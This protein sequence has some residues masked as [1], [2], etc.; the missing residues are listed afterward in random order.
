MCCETVTFVSECSFPRVRPM[1]ETSALVTMK[2]TSALATMA[3]VTQAAPFVAESCP[4]AE[5]ESSPK[6]QALHSLLRAPTR[7]GRSLATCANLAVPASASTTLSELLSRALRAINVTGSRTPWDKLGYKHHKHM[8]RPHHLYRLGARCFVV[9]L[10]DPSDRLATTIAWESNKYHRVSSHTLH[11]F[12]KT[13]Q[14]TSTARLVDVLRNRSDPLH[15]HYTAMYQAS[16]SSFV[17]VSSLGRAAAQGKVCLPSS[18]ALLPPDRWE[19][20]STRLLPAGGERCCVPLNDAN[21]PHLQPLLHANTSFVLREAGLNSNGSETSNSSCVWSGPMVH[22]LYTR[23]AMAFGDNFLI[24]Q[25]EWLKDF[26]EPELADVDVH[27]VCVNNFSRDWGRFLGQF[28][29]ELERHGAGRGTALR[30]T[31]DGE[32]PHTNPS[33]HAAPK[34][35]ANSLGYRHESQRRYVRRCLYPEDAALWR[36]VCL[37][38]GV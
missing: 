21:A 30:R 25:H 6:H 26:L 16:H 23:E 29:D 2:E 13:A 33:R 37:P 31:F 18:T 10:R 3:A 11:A 1:K 8:V 5:R 17:H 14:V 35:A 28:E 15:K 24:P 22:G 9:T 38:A 36:H 12:S 4:A 32:L 7:S 20:Q 27:V 19:Q 34:S